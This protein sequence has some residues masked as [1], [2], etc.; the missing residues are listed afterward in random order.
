MLSPEREPQV[1]TTLHGTDTTLLGSDP[2]Y[3]PAIRHALMHSDAV[4]TVSAYLEGETRRVFSFDGPIEVIHN[5]FEPKVPASSR[6]DVRRRLKLADDD[7]MILHSSNLR[8]MKRI[9][10]LLDTVAR[11]QSRHSF[12]LVILAGADFTPFKSTVTRLGLDD[13][14]IVI[15][16]VLEV[17]E[18]LQAAD[19][20]LYTSESESFCLSI[21]E[22]MFFGCPGVATSVGGIPEVVDDGVTGLLVPFGD[23]DQLARA[24]ERLMDDTELRN[25][26]GQA[27]RL[28]AQKRFSADIIVPRYELLYQKLAMKRT[29]AL[30]Q[31]V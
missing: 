22:A 29:L 4:T 9:D 1:V 20:A 14:L 17:E 10:L 15:E 25:R 12:K 28:Q 8:P 21:L 2:G 5:F 7:L 27:A 31:G 19:V 23:A 6:E 18:Y 24:V 26:L 16:N 3:G 30:E 13:K 11:I